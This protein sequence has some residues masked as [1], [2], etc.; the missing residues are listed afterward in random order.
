[1]KTPLCPNCGEE[2]VIV[3]SADVKDTGKYDICETDSH[4]GDMCENCGESPWDV[5]EEDET[6]DM[7]EV[8][9]RITPSSKFMIV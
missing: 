7:F 1:M 9:Q 5:W 4:T 2:L 8:M 3:M 6:T